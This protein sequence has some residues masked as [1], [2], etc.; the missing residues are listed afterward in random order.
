MSLVIL[1]AACI[2]VVITILTG[3]SHLILTVHQATEDPAYRT[4]HS[5]EGAPSHT[6]PVS[7]TIEERGIRKL[8]VQ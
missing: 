4:K 7:G 6:V 8:Q 5:F 3:D 1:L 2:Y